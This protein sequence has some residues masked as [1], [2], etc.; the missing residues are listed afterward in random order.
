MGKGGASI[1]ARARGKDKR[2]SRNQYDM[3]AH[4]HLIVP[5]MCCVL[6]MYMS[7]VVCVLCIKNA[8]TKY[9]HVQGQVLIHLRLFER[10]VRFN[11]WNCSEFFDRFF[12]EPYCSN[13]LGKCERARAWQLMLCFRD[14]LTTCKWWHYI[15]RAF[16][17]E[18][19]WH[20]CMYVRLHIA[21]G[22]ILMKNVVCFTSFKNCVFRATTHAFVI[23]NYLC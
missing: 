12:G 17:R 15:R 21:L 6:L 13:G 2:G 20:H 23:C 5:F 22:H 16:A 1:S 18:W 9:A 10:L 14:L 11:V 7:Y 3:G 19:T 8:T 4:V